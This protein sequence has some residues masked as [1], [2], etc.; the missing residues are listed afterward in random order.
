MIARNKVSE[1]KEEHA[2]ELEEKILQRTLELSEANESLNQKNDDLK[3][4]NI[5]LESFT[6]I[7][8]HDLQEPLRK[9]QTFADRILE[10]EFSVLSDTGKDY[11][12][13][14]HGAAK[15]MQTLIEDLLAYSHAGIR[16]R[17]FEK[18]SLGNIIEEIKLEFRDALREQK[19]VIIAEN[20]DD[21]YINHSQFR[22][23]MINL[24]MNSLKFSK[25]GVPPHIIVK[26]RIASAAYLQDE[27]HALPPGRLSPK[28]EYCHI[29]FSDNG[30]GFD[31]EYKTKIFEVF[32]RLHRKEEYAGTG[33]GLAIVKKIIDNHKGFI[34]ATGELN[35]GAIF[36]IYIPA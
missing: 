18:E 2:K 35:K 31:P 5:E 26:T 8:S 25:P 29:S 16:G 21:V 28:Q 34:K 6:F 19:V 24:L 27:N 13:R 36:D 33:I 17:V 22:Q 20:L 10:N 9:I 1:I 7:S 3:K 32:Q 11:F 14:M 30:I 15:R 4:M 12:N 23:V